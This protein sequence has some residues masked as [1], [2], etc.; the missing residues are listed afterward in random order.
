M[1]VSK[2]I[3]NAIKKSLS[4][5]DFSRLDERCSNEAQTRFVLIEPILEI[6]GYSRI[7]DMA[8]YRAYMHIV[9][10]V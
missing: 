10:C 9:L 3:V 5:F 1:P 6:L 8:L 4:K 7:D 2:P